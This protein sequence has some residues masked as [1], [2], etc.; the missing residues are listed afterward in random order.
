MASVEDLSSE[1]L[2]RGLTYAGL[3][4]VG[5]ELVKD[6]IIGP[7]KAFY[8]NITFAPGSPFLRTM[9]NT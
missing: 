2:T 6:M 9:R 4:L 3:V 5:F 1:Q 8:A 7:I